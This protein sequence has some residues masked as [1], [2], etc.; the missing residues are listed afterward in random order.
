MMFGMGGNTALLSTLLIE[1]SG[2]SLEHGFWA[3]RRTWFYRTILRRNP[4][5]PQKRVLTIGATNRIQ[6]LD[7]ALLRPGRFDKKIRIDAPA[8]LGRRDMFDYYLSKMSHDAS[9]DPTVLALET[10]GYTPS[11]IKYL[12]NE[13]L[14]CAL[15][16]GRRYVTYQDFQRAKPEHEMGLRAPLKDMNEEARERLA[17][18]VASKAAAIR[19]FMPEQRISRITIIRQGTVFGHVAFYPARESYQGM[20]TRDQYLRLLKVYSAGR[21]GEMEFCGLANQTIGVG[22]DF[23]QIRFWLNMMAQAGMFAILCANAGMRGFK[24]ELTPEMIKS[25][26]AAYQEVLRETRVE[27]R[28][29]SEMIRALVAL[30][31]EKGE[32]LADE[33]RAFFDSYGLQTP[34]PTLIRDGEEY[35]VMKPQIPAAAAGD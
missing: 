14:R 13:G 3:R 27:L 20:R 31:L 12:L 2:F 18:Y 22:G 21:A 1:M 8:A 35:Q 33:A 25:Q 28:Q 30:L 24:H 7:P 11:D 29:H 15:F 6:A 10:P 19:V 4:P 5:K 9:M 32:L 26:E 23:N 34:D 16:D 17:Y